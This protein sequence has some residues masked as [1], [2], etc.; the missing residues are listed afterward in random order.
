MILIY[1]MPAVAAGM[2]E[3]NP[4]HKFSGTKAHEFIFMSPNLNAM[5][6]IYIVTQ[7]MQLMFSE[8]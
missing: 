2:Y 7:S 3:Y 1:F 4:R 6:L 8:L 5:S